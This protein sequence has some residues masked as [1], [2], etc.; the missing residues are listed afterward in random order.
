MSTPVPFTEEE[1]QRLRYL[2]VCGL[3]CGRGLRQCG[4]GFGFGRRLRCGLQQW[5]DYIWWTYTGHENAF[6]H[7]GLIERWQGLMLS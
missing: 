5:P 3:R 6:E 7:A 1:M 2:I 4:R